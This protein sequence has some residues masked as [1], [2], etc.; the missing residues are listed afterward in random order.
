MLRSMKDHV[1]V[2]NDRP[3]EEVYLPEQ[4]AFIQQLLHDVRLTQV[5]TAFGLRS[6]W[7]F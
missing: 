1:T 2:C 5:A 6:P 3:E 7:H 4:Q